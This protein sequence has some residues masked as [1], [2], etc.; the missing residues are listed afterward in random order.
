MPSV[1]RAALSRSRSQRPAGAFRLIAAHFGLTL[2][3][4]RQQARRLVAIARPHAM[5]TVMLGDFNEWFWPASLRGALG[6]ELPRS[7]ATPNL[8]VL[9]SA[10]SSRS[11]LLLAVRRD[12]DELCRSRGAHRLRSSAG[13]R[14]HRHRLMRAMVAS[15]FDRLA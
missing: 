4:R 5:T 13:G 12:A 2:T 3:E 6:R 11:H 15:A 7:H 9:V 1:N 10:F 8:P 14:R